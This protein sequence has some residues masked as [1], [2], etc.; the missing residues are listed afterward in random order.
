M[1][2]IKEELLVAVASMLFTIADSTASLRV[3]HCLH[4]GHFV[5]YFRTR[6][7]AAFCLEGLRDMVRPPRTKCE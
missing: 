4:L 2:M 6:N 5:Y 7:Y 3:L 1:L